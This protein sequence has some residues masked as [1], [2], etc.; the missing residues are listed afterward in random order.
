MLFI[1]RHG[2]SFAPKFCWTLPP[3][4]SRIQTLI[5][6]SY[7]YLL[8][9]GKWE[10]KVQLPRLQNAPPAPARTAAAFNPMDGWKLMEHLLP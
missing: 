9:Q 3:F 5:A 1:K 2:R 6:W 4:T 7:I 10:I 8:H